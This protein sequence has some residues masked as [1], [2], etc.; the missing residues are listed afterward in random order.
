MEAGDVAFLRHSTV[1]EM[2]QT[3]EYSKYH[4]DITH[5]ETNDFIFNIGK[6]SPDY[7]EL[8]CQDGR[9]AAIADYRQCSWG[10]AP[11]DAIVT[12]SARTFH[13]RKQ[14]QMFL[15]RITELYADSVRDDPQSQQQTGGGFNNYDRNNY[16]EQSRN[17]QYDSYNNQYDSNNNGFGRNPNQNSYDRYDLNYRN[18]RLDN[19]FS[20]ERSPLDGNNTLIPY[21]KF[22]IFES[23]R[24]GKNNL[25]FQVITQS[26]LTPLYVIC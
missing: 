5:Q 26:V 3:T 25:L 24:Y 12:S 23:K 15:K 16:N 17:N 8:L 20:T 14:Y 21:E 22:R 13:E 18:E 19:S 1:T 9:R 4:L 2:L 11:A 7:F 10:Q 6:L